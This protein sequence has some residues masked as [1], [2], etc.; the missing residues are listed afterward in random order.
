MLGV[1]A[2]DRS[3]LPDPSELYAL[4]QMPYL[5]MG[6]SSAAAG[7]MLSTPITTTVRTIVTTTITSTVT[8]SAVQAGLVYTS[9]TGPRAPTSRT[10]AI[11][12]HELFY[13]FAPACLLDALVNMLMPEPASNTDEYALQ[14]MERLQE[15]AQFVRYYTVIHN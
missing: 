6:Y 13:L 15:A 7:R 11:R 14:A 4:P 5:C 8:V 10:Y 9:F 12:P 1:M 3:R 2:G